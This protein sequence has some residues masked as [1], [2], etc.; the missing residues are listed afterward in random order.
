MITVEIPLYIMQSLILEVNMETLNDILNII[1]A[2]QHLFDKIEK[3][4]HNG[5]VLFGAGQNGRWCLDYLKRNN[6]KV[7]YFIDN[8]P[9]LQ[10]TTI[11][12]IPIISFD[13]YK[14]KNLNSPI[15]ITSKHSVLAIAKTLIEVELKMPFDCWFLIK[16]I[17]EYRNILNI[18]HDEKSKNVLTLIMKTMLTGDEKYCSLIAENNQYFCMAPFF[19][20]GNETFVDLGAYT[21]DTIEKFIYA[22]NGSYKHIYAF[23]PG[24]KQID[25]MQYR[26][27]RLYKEWALKENSIT[28]NN[29][30]VSSQK[31][32]T[33]IDYCEHLLATCIT[34]K[35]VDG[36]IVQVDTLDN[37]FKN[38]NISSIKVDIEGSEI[39]ML[40]GGI[41]VIKR[42][43]PK[44]AL[45]VYHKPDDLIRSVQILTS[46]GINYNFSLRHHSSYLM[47][48]TLYCWVS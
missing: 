3:N 14:N 41:N 30:A 26:F 35:K 23:E 36:D 45:S 19:N 38:I 31:S 40:K 8:S 44:F 24:K 28:I 32:S 11:D 21:G 22:H 7:N 37:Y 2:K 42:D 29:M 1:N 13:E 17:Q 27:E 34:N 20:T 46:L 39:D 4:I 18:F 25:A 43:K 9:K 6:L 33:T 10:H 47:D 12:N 15:L 48:T 5:I 16:N